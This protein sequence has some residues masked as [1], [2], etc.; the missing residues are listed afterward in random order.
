MN[1]IAIDIRYLSKHPTG[2]GRYIQKLLIHLRRIPS[3]KAALYLLGHPSN[4]QH[5][6]KNYDRFKKIHSPYLP[7]LH[8]IADWWFYQSLPKLLQKHEINLFHATALGAPLHQ[9][10]I[11][12]IV[13]IHDLVGYESPSTL[14]FF[15]RQYLNWQTA[16]AMKNA[17]RLIA[18]TNSVVSDIT[19]HF[20]D[21]PP[22]TVIPL[23]FEKKGRGG[24]IILIQDLESKIVLFFL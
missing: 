19:R 24:A 8:P 7:E 14:P 22:V 5:L 16:L 2:V 23:G 6:P 1:R 10:D 4:F 11:P 3:N 12:W 21:H 20:P 13:T 15:F 17:T 9:P 18:T